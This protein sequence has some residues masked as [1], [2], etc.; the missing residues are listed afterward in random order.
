[1]AAQILAM[2]RMR[3]V[4]AEDEIGHRLL[5]LLGGVAPLW[6][7]GRAVRKRRVHRRKLVEERHELVGSVHWRTSSSARSRRAVSAAAGWLHGCGN[8][9]GGVS[10]T[11]VPCVHSIHTAAERINWE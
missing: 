11:R 8:C 4:G 2:P 7:D 5:L 10:D 6:K 3:V 1:M 9:C